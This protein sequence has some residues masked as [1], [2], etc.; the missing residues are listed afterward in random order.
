MSNSATHSGTDVLGGSAKFDSDLSV[1]PLLSAQV[2]TPIAMSAPPLTAPPLTAPSLANHAHPMQHLPPPML[3]RPA[4]QSTQNSA[5]APPPL[6]RMSTNNGEDESLQLA[7]DSEMDME[8]DT[9]PSSTS[10]FSQSSKVSSLDSL[11]GKIRATKQVADR[12]TPDINGRDSTS[13]PN[14]AITTPSVS[15][16]S[17]GA[18]DS[19]LVATPP[20]LRKCV[21]SPDPNKSRR[22]QAAPQATN[23]RVTESP[24]REDP[25]CDI[26]TPG[27]FALVANDRLK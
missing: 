2:R 14:T 6:K 19:S 9:I 20:P 10:L 5:R 22:K 1:P 16:T 18:A 13:S 25:P 8:A 23:D 4:V 27:M 12:K 26:I 17:F 15:D 24:T 7:S 11:L 21:P 3:A